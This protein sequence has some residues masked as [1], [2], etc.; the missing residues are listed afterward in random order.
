MYYKMNK[1]ILLL[2]LILILEELSIKLPSREI[3]LCFFNI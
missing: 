2:I 3:D 1:L